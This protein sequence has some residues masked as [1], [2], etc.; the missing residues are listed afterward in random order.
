MAKKK[1]GGMEKIHL[2]HLLPVWM[3]KGKNPIEIQRLLSFSS[4]SEPKKEFTPKT[5]LRK[6]NSP[7]IKS[8]KYKH[9]KCLACGRAGSGKFT[10]VGYGKYLC[11]RCQMPS[12][13]KKKD[14]HPKSI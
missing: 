9:L 2:Y 10:Y 12:P 6:P 13:K 8:L 1:L 4:K 7:I 14:A 3:R 11:E 5:I